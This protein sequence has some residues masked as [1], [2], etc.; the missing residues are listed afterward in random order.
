VNEPDAGAAPATE[1]VSPALR[2]LSGLV[3]RGSELGRLLGHLDARRS[4]RLEATRGAGATALLRAV[5]GE[6]PR[7]GTV[8]GTLALPVGLPVA[9]LAAVAQRM[10]PEVSSTVAQRHMLVL[11]DDR[12]LRPDDV[13]VLLETFPRSVLVVTGPPDS[14]G[15]GLAPV[16]VTG[17]S[18]HHAV[19]LVE[20]AMGRPLTIDEGRSARD[21]ATAVEGMPGPLVQAAAAVRDGGLTFDEVLDLLD[22]PPRPT[23]LA[24]TLQH[25]LD[26]DLHVTLSHLRALG[27]VPATSRLAAVAAD[28]P[29]EQAVRRL[30]RL[31]VLGLVLTDGRD[32]WT[33]ASGIPTVSE[34]V[35]VQVADRVAAWLDTTDEALTVFDIATVLSVVADRVAAGDRTTTLALST[36]ARDRLPLAGLV[37]TTAL[38]DGAAEWAT[39]EP[40]AQPDREDGPGADVVV[41]TVESGAASPA[42]TTIAAA[43][44]GVATTTADDTT[45]DD[46]VTVA[47]PDEPGTATA[48]GAIPV[49]DEP[50]TSPLSGLLTSR[51][52]LALVAVAAAALIAAVL[53]VVP[54]LRPDDSPDAVRSDVDLGVASVGDSASGTLTLDLSGSEAAVPVALVLSGPDADAFSVDPGRC[55]TLD[56]RASVRFTPDRSGTH[57]AN[58]TAVDSG[59]V[60]L[61]VVALTGTGTGDPAPATP[62]TNLAVTLFPSDPAP[63]PG[64]GSGVVPIGVRNNGPDDSTGARLVVTVPPRVTAE[65]EGCSFEDAALTCPLAAL[66]A[67]QQELIAVTL[68]VPNRAEQVRVDAAVR[69]LTDADEADSDNAAGFVYAVRPKGQA[70]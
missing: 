58:V 66:P 33:A 14:A 11:L 62:V 67:G 59:Q 29:I 44:P 18:Q 50:A 24:V 47:A 38:L 12:D 1:A 26:D 23:A 36:V 54:S 40:V 8:D 60:D 52:G 65:A 41:E 43:A 37:A 20:A 46:A 53:L 10:Q 3:G 32:G 70:G 49:D 27:D 42:A 45:A 19:G 61:A 5:C 57:V 17:L 21:V 4:V 48:T 9:D 35:R 56:C 34:P 39:P 16:S 15:D 30:R 13:D 68:S 6:P 7:P 63:L 31:S 22:S 25:A 69:P 51:R 55:D 2:P 28:L 64:G